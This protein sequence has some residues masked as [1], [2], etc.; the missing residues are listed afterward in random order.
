[1]TR[2]RK[3]HFCT[4]ARAARS[5]SMTQPDTVTLSGMPE[6]STCTAAS[7][8]ASPVIPSG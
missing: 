7:H 4:A 2:G 1:M 3:V 5:H 6:V 8:E